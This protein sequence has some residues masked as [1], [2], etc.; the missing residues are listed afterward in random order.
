MSKKKIESSK[1]CVDQALSEKI[2][3][4]LDLFFLGI[5]VF[6]NKDSFLSW[7]HFNC[8]TLGDKP[9]KLIGNTT[10]LQAVKEELMRIQYGVYS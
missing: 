4:L 7:L 2:I 8:L 1:D 6:G 10:G 3:E 5:E 9:I